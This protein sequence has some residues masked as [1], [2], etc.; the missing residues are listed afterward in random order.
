MTDT[1]NNHEHDDLATK[2]E[3]ADFKVAI[4][5]AILALTNSNVAANARMEQFETE[6]H[7]IRDLLQDVHGSVRNLIETNR[8]AI[9]FTSS[10]E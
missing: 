5:D 7:A 3:L 6:L 4:A 10:E 1:D 8:R 9:G 2:E